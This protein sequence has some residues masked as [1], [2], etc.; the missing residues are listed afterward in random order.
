MSETCPACGAEASGRF[1]NQCGV[2]LNAACPECGNPLPRGARFC[3]HCGAA[4]A[5]RGGGS[6][7]RSPLPW[8][9]AALAVVALLALLLLPRLRPTAETQAAAPPFAAAPAGGA[10][11]EGGG[12]ASVDLS[13]MTPREAADRLFNRVMTA[14]A[15][16][17]TVQAQRFLPMAMGAYQRVDTV[18]ADL[19]YHVAALDMVGHDYASAKAQADTI[20]IGS[21]THLFGL[22]TAAQAEAGAGHTAAAREFYQRFLAAYD[23]ESA[24]RLPEYQEHAQGLPAMRDEARGASAPG[25]R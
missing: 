8:V 11:D 16:G 2:A 17:D 19:R 15:S 10:A 18:D 20:L 22:F 6:E 24:K 9:I 12:P 13:S 21:P 5:A 3:N 23:A 7:R 14:M 25:N 1:C 4:V